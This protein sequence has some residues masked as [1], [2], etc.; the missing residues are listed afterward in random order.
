LVDVFVDIWPCR[1]RVQVDKHPRHIFHRGQYFDHFA[2]GFSW[3]ANFAITSCGLYKLW[4]C[5]SK[6]N[7]Y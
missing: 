3:P 6:E 5:S 2:A 7:I 4:D 1:I